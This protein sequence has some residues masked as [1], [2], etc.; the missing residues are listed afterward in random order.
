MSQQISGQNSKVMDALLPE[1]W[2]DNRLVAMKFAQKFR[3]LCRSQGWTQRSLAEKLGTVSPSTISNWGQGVFMPRIDEVV[4]LAEVLGVSVQYL[5]RDDL[6][7]DTADG[8][9]ADERKL[10]WLA[11]LVGMETALRRV[12]KGDE[13]ELVT[14]R[15][16]PSQTMLYGESDRAEVASRTRVAGDDVAEKQHGEESE[17][18]Q[19]GAAGEPGTNQPPRKHEPPRIVAMQ[20]TTEALYREERERSRAKRKEDVKKTEGKSKPKPKGGK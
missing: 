15:S 14:A 12:A 16:R 8:L 11:D 19:L 1:V 17:P 2:P 9:T 10:L 20:N 6:D 5:V 18:D 13:E 4:K 3:K 7:E